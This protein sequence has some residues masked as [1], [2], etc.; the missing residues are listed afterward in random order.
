MY[1]GKKKCPEQIKSDNEFIAECDKTFSSRKEASQYYVWKGWEYFYK[2]DLDSSMKRFNQAWLLDKTNSEIFWGFGNLL[3]MKR[4][5]KES[6]PLF[7]KSI[8]LNPNNSKVYESLSTSYGY[9]FNETKKV[10][11]LKSTIDNLKKAIKLD[12]EN[13]D[14][15]GKISNAYMFFMQKDSLRKYI[16]IAENLGSKNIDPEAKRIA[17]QK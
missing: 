9:L 1:G 15:Y 2:N 7:E 11:Y 3:G 4:Q 14:L 12:K 17:N 8:E 13:P 5:I 16:K 10:E 6:I